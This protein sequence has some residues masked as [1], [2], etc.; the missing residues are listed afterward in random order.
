MIRLS[1]TALMI[2]IAGQQTASAQQIAVQQPVIGN[3]AVGTTVSVPDRGS[4]VLGG[5]GAAASGQSTYSPLPFNSSFGWSR[6]AS[7]MSVHVQIHDLAAMDE[8]VFAA[9]GSR[10]PSRI[11]PMIVERITHRDRSPA[12]AAET[13]DHVSLAVQAE[14]LAEQAEARGKPSVAKLHWQR[15]AKHGSALAKSRLGALAKGVAIRP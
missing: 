10:K 4:V 12:P 14:R 13:V 15:A 7:S 5:V 1:C 9:A 2:V 3:F 8:A 11:D 6:S